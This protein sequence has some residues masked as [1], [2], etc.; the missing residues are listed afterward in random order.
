MSRPVN[1]RLRANKVVFNLAKYFYITVF[2]NFKFHVKSCSGLP[3]VLYIN[4]W[5]G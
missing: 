5:L 2:V 1:E 3:H 4:T